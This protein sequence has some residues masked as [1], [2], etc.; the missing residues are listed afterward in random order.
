MKIAVI[1]FFALFIAAFGYFK[2]QVNDPTDKIDYDDRGGLGRSIE[3]PFE[4]QTLVSGKPTVNTS[5]SRS[6][7]MTISR[8]LEFCNNSSIGVNQEIKTLRETL[9]HNI[10]ERYDS[11]KLQYALIVLGNQQLLNTQNMTHFFEK[12]LL[13]NWDKAKPLIAHYDVEK[14]EKKFEFF[15]KYLELSELLEIDDLKGIQEWVFNN[16][17]L[18]DT[19]LRVNRREQEI[20]HSVAELIANSL[21]SLS[22]NT[23]GWVIENINFDVKSISYAIK[24]EVPISLLDSILDKTEKINTL[25]LQ[26]NGKPGNL[27]TMALLNESD[28][29]VI[30]LLSDKIN[31]NLTPLI[32]PPINQYVNYLKNK[33]MIEQGDI[34]RLEL[35]NSQGHEV[36]LWPNPKT[37]KM[38]LQGYYGESIPNYVIDSL[39]QIAISKNIKNNWDEPNGE[40]LP[41]DDLFWLT[42]RTDVFKADFDA[43]QKKSSDCKAIMKKQIPLEPPYQDINSYRDLVIDLKSNREKLFKLK[44]LSPV[45]NDMFVNEL[46]L[47]GNEKD[48]LE[49][50]EW[51]ELFHDKSYINLLAKGDEAMPHQQNYLA[52]EIC[53]RYGAMSLIEIFSR[54]WFIELSDNLFEQCLGENNQWIHEEYAIHRPIFPSRTYLAI[55]NI[56]YDKVATFINDG[57]LTHGYSDGRDSLALILDRMVPFRAKVSPQIFAL[58]ELLLQV[59]ELQPMH[60][61]RLN[62]LE[63]KYPNYF[64]DLASKYPNLNKAESYPVNN[65]VSFI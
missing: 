34:D 31:L 33:G 36:E 56:Q 2:F 61:R 3:E 20:Y 35:L 28:D 10:T 62:R 53:N 5:L 48:F 40:Q 21:G 12:S 39:K 1:A 25:F 42:Q 59:T 60:Y 65:Y 7:I 14:D 32:T 30:Q 4:K 11:D 19:E 57:E 22:E 49:V 63:L 17:Q 44:T 38:E 26:E 45:L 58:M 37:R 27:L 52:S 16:K 6:E 50:N 24:S 18:L 54:Q 43:S 13:D 51:L 29:K 64:N 23:V 55:K 9:I 15:K 47:K 41:S 46:I 8:E